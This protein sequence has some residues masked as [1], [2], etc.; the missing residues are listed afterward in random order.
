MLDRFDGYL[1]RLTRIGLHEGFRDQLQQIEIAGLILRQQHQLI[2]F[3]LFFDA[4]KAAI[5]LFLAADRQ[6][7]ADDRLNT[8]F[9]AGRRKFQ[10]AE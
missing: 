6:L 4:A 10:R 9:G 2:G 1:R 3:G 7:N 8:G 5:G